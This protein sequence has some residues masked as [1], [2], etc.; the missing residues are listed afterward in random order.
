MNSEEVMNMCEKLAG[1]YKSPQHHDDLVS[2]GILACYEVLAQD[3]NPHPAHLWRMANR[4]MYDYLNIDTA[5][6]SVPKSDT[7]RKVSRGSGEH[8]G[9]YSDAGIRNLH[10]ALRGEVVSLDD[11]MAFSP[12]HADQYEKDE[13]EA[14]V[15]TVAVTTLNLDELRVLKGRFFDDMSLEQLSVELGVS[16][17]TVSRWEAAMLDKLRNNL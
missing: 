16:E 8:T 17:S 2:E 10:Y 1:R 15:M 3:D 13:Y 12:D 7:A 14:Y 6:L 11:F 5:P 4:R 9:G